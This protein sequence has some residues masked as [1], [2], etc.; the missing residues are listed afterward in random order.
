M[1]FGGGGGNVKAC[2]LFLWCC[3]NILDKCSLAE[4]LLGSLVLSWCLP[5]EATLMSQQLNCGCVLDSSDNNV[6]SHDLICL[7]L[8]IKYTWRLI[9][10]KRFCPQD[11]LT[12]NTEAILTS[13]GYMYMCFVPTNP[14]KLC[15]VI[16][17][18]WWCKLQ[19][20]CFCFCGFASNCMLILPPCQMSWVVFI[21]SCTLFV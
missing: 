3:V 16:S 5:S 17:G 15:N 18:S 6:Q 9:I 21:F 20:H 19:W 1:C 4:T 2:N 10:L 12:N 8:L 13:Y 11:S 7:S 14:L